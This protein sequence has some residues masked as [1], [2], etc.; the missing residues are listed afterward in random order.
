MLRSWSLAV[1][2]AVAV[3]LA[4][5]LALAL[6]LL[7]APQR[8]HLLTLGCPRCE[9]GAPSSMPRAHTHASRWGRLGRC[10]LVGLRPE[11]PNPRFRQQLA[12]SNGC[13][14]PPAQ[15]H[16]SNF[17]SAPGC[18]RSGPCQGPIDG[19]R[20]GVKRPS[21]DTIPEPRACF[22]WVSR[23]FVFFVSI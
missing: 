20:S 5:A 10:D 12:A 13:Q 21:H 8:G 6:D 1:A 11:R 16:Y 9:R 22:V 23:D 14:V 2:V 7:S 17:N 19:T 4:L 3:A 15:K 18:R